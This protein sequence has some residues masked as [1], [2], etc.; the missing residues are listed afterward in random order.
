MGNDHFDSHKGNANVVLTWPFTLQKLFNRMRPY[1]PTDENSLFSIGPIRLNIQERRVQCLG[2]EASTTPQ[3][4]KLL[5]V[6]MDHPGEVIERQELFRQV[7]DTEYTADTRTLDVHITWWRQAI[8]I[9][10]RQPRFLKTIRGLGY[11]LDI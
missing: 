11:R 3:L 1:L 5:K 9:D 4:V 2:S 8:E 7:W 10:P 6:L